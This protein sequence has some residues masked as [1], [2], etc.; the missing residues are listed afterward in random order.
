MKYPRVS[1]IN[2]SPHTVTYPIRP[3][4]WYGLNQRTPHRFLLLSPMLALPQLPRMWPSVL[5]AVGT[6]NP[7]FL[8][9]LPASFARLWSDPNAFSSQSCTL[10]QRVAPP[11]CCT[12][13]SICFVCFFWW[14]LS[15][16]SELA[17]TH[18]FLVANL[19]A[20]SLLVLPARLIGFR[21]QIGNPLCP[22]VCITSPLWMLPKHCYI[23]GGSHSRITFCTAATTL[24]PLGIRSLSH[25]LAK[26]TACSLSGSGLSISHLLLS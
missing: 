23:T 7:W 5:V 12:A 18:R 13:P 3:W 15:G 1:Q 8:P 22:P 26:I 25:L 14:Q 2:N 16:F 24:S 19:P 10:V 11:P 21:F 9:Q 6:G 17:G 4:P 20:S